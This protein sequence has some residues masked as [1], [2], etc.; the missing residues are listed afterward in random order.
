MKKLLASTI[1]GALILCVACCAF[2]D[3][4]PPYFYDVTVTLTDGT[5][6][7]GGSY[8]LLGFFGSRLSPNA[9]K[10]VVLSYTPGTIQ[11]HVTFFDNPETKTYERSGDRVSALDLSVYTEYDI[12][13]KQPGSRK[14]FWIKEKVEVLLVNIVRVDTLKIIG[15]GFAISQDPAVYANVKEPYLMVETCGLGCPAKFFSEDPSITKEKL[16]ELWDKY[17]DCK[18]RS[19]LTLKRYKRMEKVMSKYKLKI[20]ADPFCI[21]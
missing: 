20:L 6:I 19:T 2:G 18:I 13:E 15:K 4:Q 10:S 7:T 16:Q 12:I 8:G 21:D 3:L 9:V 14:Y 17:L 1:A 5:S 11:G